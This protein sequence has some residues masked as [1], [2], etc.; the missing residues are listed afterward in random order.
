MSLSNRNF[1]I[2]F[3]SKEYFTNNSSTPS[4]AARKFFSNINKSNQIKSK[5]EFSVKETTNGSKK[6][7]Y[8]PYIGSKNNVYLKK[9][10]K[11]IKGGYNNPQSNNIDFAKKGNN[12]IFFKPVLLNDKYYY[13]YIVCKTIFKNYEFKM[14]IGNKIKKIEIMT[15]D[16]NTL[17]KLKE[18]INKNNIF[19][20]L[21]EII[22][23]VIKTKNESVKKFENKELEIK[24]LEN[25]TESINL[26]KLL[27]KEAFIQQLSNNN[28]NTVI[29][30]G[31]LRIKK[32]S[33]NGVTYIFFNPVPLTSENN[34]TNPIYS[35]KNNKYLYKYQLK[36]Y[37]Y[38][39]IFYVKDNQRMFKE[40]F[41]NRE[42]SEISI[43]QIDISQINQENLAKLNN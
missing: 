29:T 4:L 38:R 3:N 18:Y 1:T 2:L 26:D 9:S 36:N 17:I 28:N 40:I 20:T 37:Y 11:I 12:C 13:Q 14:T 32:L 8:G 43:R 31:D 33:I 23:N 10:K 25:E 41:L 34:K 5:I 19:R 15:I 30:L 16:K 6:K 35:T 22:D 27:I 7:I 39:Y 21:Q 24:K 42:T